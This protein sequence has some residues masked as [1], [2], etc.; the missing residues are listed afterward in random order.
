M[1]DRL[2][3]RFVASDL[4]T[5]A[6]RA[7]V[8]E[9]YWSLRR[10]VPIVYLLGFVNLAGMELA[11]G[12]RLSP[13]INLPSFIVLCAVIRLVNWFAGGKGPTHEEMVRRMRQTV[14]FAA[15][16]CLAVCARCIY[17]FGIG[18]TSS[19]MAV[20]L[21]GGLTAIGVSY[22]LTAL[23]AA[24]RIPLVLIIV[25]ISIVALMSHD[26]LFAWAAFGLV[27]VAALTMRLLAQ[28]SRHFTDVVH[29]RAMIALQQERAEHAH[30]E[31]IIA[32]TTDFLTSLPNR[33]AFMTALEA[34]AVESAKSGSFA[35]AV[36][37]LDRF[38]TVN[39][40]LGHAAG[41]KLLQE[42]AVRLVEAV[43]QQGLV[44]R[45]GGDEFGI[46]LPGIDR[47]CA[48]QGIGQR[49][50]DKVNRPV[51]IKGREVAVSACCG[52]GISRRGVDK[53]PSRIMADADLALYEAKGNSSSGLAV[54]ELQME[55]PRRRR[56]QIE[57][58]LRSPTVCGDLRV[59]FQPIIQLSNGRIVAHEALARW[60]DPE[61]GPVSPAEF[62]PIAEQLNLIDEINNHLMAVAFTEART[63]P[64]DVRLSFNLS[65]IQLCSQGSAKAILRALD[66]AK[67]TPVRLQVEVTE[68]ALLVDLERA[69]E[70]LARLKDAGVTI[71][72]DD[73]GAGFASIG[74]LRELRFDQIKLDGA[75]VTAA[76]DS[77]DG[78]RLLS[79]VIGL[80][81]ILGV[82]SVAEHVESE[83]LLK[84]LVELGC[85]AGQGFW[86]KPPAPADEIAA[87][88]LMQSFRRRAA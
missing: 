14:W 86:L 77:A 33:R 29:S 20:M 23:P 72:L 17:L 80:C 5:A 10:Q 81:D 70:N 85:T 31:A 69:R 13:G 46:L 37:D 52:L 3:Q 78:K 60:T 49:I 54:F 64:D 7:L 44:A 26:P 58:A 75:L 22:G 1:I 16:V 15:A 62:V 38:K 87:M 24:G 8:E 12:G 48:A 11:T 84:L 55:A 39:D 40:T 66:K 56:L 47:S 35:V 19:H 2:M 4:T 71:V 88:P 6:G 45:L 41:D 32:A 28:H 21:F 82:S 25:P 61:L 34:E 51:F 59:V 67:L 65:A 27:V 63:W 73:F 76:L 43:G 68:T 83:D 9:R 50:L 42:V 18:N 53:S 30:L 36:L 79:A 74:Y 57:Q